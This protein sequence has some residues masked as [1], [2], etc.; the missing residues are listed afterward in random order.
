MLGQLDQIEQD[1]LAALEAVQDETALEQWRVAH[2]GRSSALMGTFDR[3]GEL[4][5]E[6]RPA[7]GRR[8]NEV[9]RSLEGAL[10]ARGEMLR[11]A[12]LARSMQAER[13]DV[14]L[15]GRNLGRGRLHPTTQT[16]RQIYRI[17]ADMGFQIYR[18]REVETDE[19]NFQL[20]NFPPNHPAR[21][22]WDS[23]YIDTGTER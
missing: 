3:L 4:P 20:L 5:K 12:A 21:E 9:K 16:M 14:T 18:S 6:E 7:I 22:M 19:Y 1:A 11:Q 15:P 13:L 17:F 2:L 10:A 23:F 8:A